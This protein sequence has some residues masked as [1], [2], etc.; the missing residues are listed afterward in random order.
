MNWKPLHL[1]TNVSTSVGAVME[2]AGTA[3]SVDRLSQSQGSNR[4]AVEE[5]AMARMLSRT[6][7]TGK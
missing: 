6:R 1:L 3:G 5:S 2:P 7:S 4:R